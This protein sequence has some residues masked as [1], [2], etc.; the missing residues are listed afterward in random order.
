M[1][2]GHSAVG[3]R[4]RE[5]SLWANPSVFLSLTCSK[6]LQGP[7][8]GEEPSP[9]RSSLS[10]T[11]PLLSDHEQIFIAL[12]Y[13]VCCKSWSSHLK[14]ILEAIEKG[15]EEIKIYMVFQ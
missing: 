8:M 12:V 13:E 5:R 4:E 6:G 14:T 3:F 10:S 1:P 11:T 7:Q 2:M 15:L 9:L